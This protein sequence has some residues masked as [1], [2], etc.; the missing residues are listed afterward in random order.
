MTRGHGKW[1]RGQR[2][3]SPGT[4]SVTRDV[5]STLQPSDPSV[6][7][8]MFG[9]AVFAHRWQRWRISLGA[10]LQNVGRYVARGHPVRAV[11]GVWPFVGRAVVSDL[12][13]GSR[14]ELRRPGLLEM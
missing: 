6:V 7:S 12:V 3:Y 11:L 10:Q 2:G 4:A 14:S 5:S 13:C 8:A 9:R 1:L